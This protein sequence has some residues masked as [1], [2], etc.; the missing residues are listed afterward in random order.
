MNTTPRIVPFFPFLSAIRSVLLT[1]ALLGP[2]SPSGKAGQAPRSDTPP[3]F[4]LD[5][6]TSPVRKIPALKQGKRAKRPHEWLRNPDFRQ[7]WNHWLP[8]GSGRWKVL[9]PQSAQPRLEAV[10]GKGPCTVTQ[11]LV[12]GIDGRL[13]TT[14]LQAAVQ[15]N[16]GGSVKLTSWGVEPTGGREK[17]F[18]FRPLGT[19]VLRPGT[20]PPVRLPPETVILSCTLQAAPKGAVFRKVSLTARSPAS[21]DMAESACLPLFP[22][23]LRDRLADGDNLRVMCLTE[24]NRNG[25]KNRTE[26]EAP[27]FY[28]RRFAEF[29]ETRTHGTVD[30]SILPPGRNPADTL[31][32][33]LASPPPAGPPPDLVLMTTNWHSRPPRWPLTLDEAGA[34][35]EAALLLLHKRYPEAEILLIDDNLSRFSP[36]WSSAAARLSRTHGIGLAVP[37]LSIRNLHLARGVPEPPSPPSHSGP[38]HSLYTPLVPPAEQ[39][40]QS[41]GLVR[42]W[43][44]AS[45]ARPQNFSLRPTA[46]RP[47]PWLGDVA[48]HPVTESPWDLYGTGWDL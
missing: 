3:S 48:I 22:T 44:A 25:G 30:L 1:T 11:Y 7:G 38:E 37:A 21:A 5:S 46:Y 35:M 34:M 36:F 23:A 45:D 8:D 31:W 24:A 2:I 16:G 29:L 43:D 19:R 13:G 40:L 28:L 9:A 41:L 6:V 10:P 26:T 33:L 14:L 18:A 47:E 32:H 27:R 17:L 12:A 4:L 20:T 42:Y 15:V 39:W